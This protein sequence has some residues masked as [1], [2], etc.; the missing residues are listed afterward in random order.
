MLSKNTRIETYTT[1]I[2]YAVLY[3]S[4]TWPLTL[5]EGI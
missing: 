5:K 4:E 1:V 3:E 2:L